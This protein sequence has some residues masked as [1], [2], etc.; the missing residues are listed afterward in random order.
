MSTISPFCLAFRG[1]NRAGERG[2]KCGICIRKT[3]R[4]RKELESLTV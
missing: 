4:Y 1:Q 3:K 2:S